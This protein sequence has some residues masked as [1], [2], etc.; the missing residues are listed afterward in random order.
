MQ[1]LKTSN[2]NKQDKKIW[3]EKHIEEKVAECKVAMYAK[4]KKYQWYIDS[5][6][7]KNM[8]G[9][10]G[11]FIILTK[12]DKGKVTFGDNVSAKILE[13]GTVSLGNKRNKA[14]NVLLVEN[15]KPNI[16]SLSQSCHREHILI[17]N[18]QKFE[19]RK[20]G[21]GKLVS[22]APRTSSNVYILDI[23]EEE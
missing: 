1:S 13:K 23:E 19:I 3:K 8:T 12:K 22:I 20:E 5:G 21:L 2:S 16:L 15:I 7:S 14:K 10:E 9:D 18:S 17:F 6:C 4:N 11:K